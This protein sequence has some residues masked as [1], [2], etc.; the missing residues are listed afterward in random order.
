M[1][2]CTLFEFRNAMVMPYKMLTTLKH[3]EADMSTLTRSK[4]F[5]ECRI[6]DGNEHMLLYAPIERESML[7]VHNANKALQGAYSQGFIRIN[8]YPEEMLRL[9][10]SNMSLNLDSRCTLIAETMPEGDLLESA[11]NSMS[12]RELLEGLAGLDAML[13]R[14][15]V[16]HNNLTAR[17]IIIDRDGRWLP[18]RQYYSTRG[19]GGDK[20]GMERLCKLIEEHT[21]PMPEVDMATIGEWYREPTKPIDAYLEGR[22]Q[23]RTARGVGFEDEFGKMVIEDRFVWASDFMENRAMVTTQDNRMG[24]IDRMGREIIPTIYDSVR[25]SVDSGKTIVVCN[26]MCA[27]FDYNGQQITPWVEQAKIDNL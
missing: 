5:A 8:I 13:R 3:I 16:S 22:R 25:Y 21:T 14:C 1:D 15:D 2:R 23:V 27:V 20:R 6:S 24:V 18:I 10:T 9:N 7:M 4:Y 11:I 19:Y 26:D 17:S 12:R